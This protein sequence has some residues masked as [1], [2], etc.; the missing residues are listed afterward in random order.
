MTE[1]VIEDPDD[2][3]V[4]RLLWA[5]VVSYVAVFAMVFVG[6]WYV[7]HE[8]INS[9]QKWCELLVTLDN[10]IPPD[11]DSPRS[12]DAATKF[13]RLRINLGC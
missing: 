2:V 8:I 13:H 7:N 3:V 1:P 4:R 11:K 10:P 9:N 5:V 12:V 6:I